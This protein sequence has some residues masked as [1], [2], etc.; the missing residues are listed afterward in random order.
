MTEANVIGYTANIQVVVNEITV[1]IM[2]CYC[3]SKNLPGF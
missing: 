1:R 2:N 3:L